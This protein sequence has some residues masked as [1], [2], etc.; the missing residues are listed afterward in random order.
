MVRFFYMEFREIDI[1]LFFSFDFF[2]ILSC[3]LREVT[4]AER[5]RKKE[6]GSS[7]RTSQKS[8]KMQEMSVG[9]KKNFFVN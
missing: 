5:A 8:A 4:P 6:K 3:V 2:P 7:K 1:C 9:E